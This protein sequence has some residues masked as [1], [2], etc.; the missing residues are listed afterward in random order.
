M[1]FGVPR[2]CMAMYGRPSWPS[3]FHISPQPPLTSFTTNGPM[4]SNALLTTSGR[5]V[6]MEILTP[7]CSAARIRSAGSS[8]LHSS[9]PLMESDPGRVEHAPRSRMSAP[10]S[11]IFTILPRKPSS[12]K[13]PSGRRLRLP[14]KNESSVRLTMPITWIFL[15]TELPIMVKISAKLDKK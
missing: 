2:V 13:V 14:A 8:L 7:G 6:S 10:E 15:S 12:S 1:F 4:M 9:S 11:S 3:N 5:K